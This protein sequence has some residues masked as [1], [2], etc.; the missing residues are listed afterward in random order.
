MASRFPL[1]AADLSCTICCEIFKDPVVLKCSH[2]F[3]GPCLK[4]LWARQSQVHDCPLCRRPVRGEPVPSLTIRNLCEAFVQDE[5]D[6]DDDNDE[7]NDDDLDLKPREMCPIHRK[8]LKLFCRFDQEPICEVCKTSKRHKRHECCPVNEAMADFKLKLELER[9]TLH[10]KVTALNA[11]KST[12]ENT[13]AHIQVQACFVEKCMRDEFSRLRCFLMAEEAAR[14]VDLRK[15]VKQKIRAAQAK[16]EDINVQLK[17]ISDIVR[18]VEE[19]LASTSVSVLKNG[20]GPTAG[21]DILL[22]S[23]AAISG[24]LVDETKYL[25]SLSFQVWE[26]MRGIVKMDGCLLLG[27]YDD[28]DSLEN[29]DDEDSDDEVISAE[30]DV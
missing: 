1:V 25:G 28:D 18:V 19:K 16:T 4:R 29:S 11:A 7:D 22:Y 5:D 13:E 12:H 23:H 10:E 2:S 8:E 15:E 3:C 24:F 26:K 9:R 6:H 17:A 14:V 21:A 30:L 20:K 27:K